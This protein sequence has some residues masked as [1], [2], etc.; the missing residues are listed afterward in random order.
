MTVVLLSSGIK[1]ADANKY[2]QGASLIETETGDRKQEAVCYEW[3]GALFQRLCDAV[4]A[5]NHYE[6]T[7]AIS[8]KIGDRVTQAEIYADLGS[9]CITKNDY[10]EADEFLKKALSIVKEGQDFQLEL[11]CNANFEEAKIPQGKK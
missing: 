10:S 5:K 3:P 4:N 9:L 6:E 8:V 1:F 7:L 2:F 11:F